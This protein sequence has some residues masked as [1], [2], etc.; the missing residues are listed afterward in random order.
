MQPGNI[1]AAAGR[2]QEAMEQLSIA[3]GSAREFW[4]D[5]QA[6]RFEEQQ[7]RPV[8]ECINIALPALSQMSQALQA[9]AVQC[10][11]PGERPGL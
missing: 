6:V 1:V 11:E 7:I 10:N 9:A 3:W 5:A 2:L 8:M 4:N